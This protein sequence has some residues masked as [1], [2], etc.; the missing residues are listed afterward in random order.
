MTPEQLIAWVKAEIEG[1]KKIADNT[2][3]P[4]DV[5]TYQNGRISALYEIIPHVIMLLPPPTTL[6]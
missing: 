5:R 6:S 2:L 4:D 3:L 1:A